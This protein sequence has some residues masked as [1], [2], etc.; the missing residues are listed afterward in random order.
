MESIN[1]EIEQREHLGEQSSARAM[2]G[3]ARQGIPGLYCTIV[4]YLLHPA[5]KLEHEH[6]DTVQ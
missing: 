2:P 1:L 4:L 3:K 5:N 6:E